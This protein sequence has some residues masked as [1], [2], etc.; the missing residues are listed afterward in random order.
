MSALPT[1]GRTGFGGRRSRTLVAALVVVALTAGSLFYL[2]SRSGHGGGDTAQ[3]LSLA[4]APGEVHHY[5]MTIDLKGGLGAAGAKLPFDMKMSGTLLWRVVAVDKKGVAHVYVSLQNGTATVNGQ[6]GPLGDD[7]M[8]L[9]IAQDGR[10]LSGCTFGG[11]GAGY[12]ASI[13][14]PGASELTPVLPDGAVAPGA[15]WSKSFVQHF[16]SATGGVRFATTDT[17]VR[18][19][20][21][22]GVHAAVVRTNANARLNATV[23]LRKLAAEYQFPSGLGKGED[24][25]FH[26]SGTIRSTITSWIDSGS[27]ELVRESVGST[28]DVKLAGIDLPADDRL[29]GGTVRFAGTESLTLDRV[30]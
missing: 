26:Y 28:F 30:D 15:T 24:P 23:D 11:P 13:G 22:D 12:I 10:I 7:H 27:K 16:P 14:I 21:V 5:R 2:F 4:L 8:T 20:D 9:R 1:A 19:E 3:A 17:Y 25:K 29:P 6:S 18:A